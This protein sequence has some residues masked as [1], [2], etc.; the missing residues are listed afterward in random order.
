MTDPTVTIQLLTSADT[1]IL[2]NVAEDVFDNAVNADWAAEFLSDLRHHIF[3]AID[4][5]EVIGMAT[6]VHYLHPDKPPEL[7]VN[8][9]A[10]AAS[11]LKQGVAKRLMTALLDH[12]RVLGCVMAWVGTAVDNLAAQHLYTSVGGHPDPETFI[13]FEFDLKQDKP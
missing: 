6:G 3:V 11:H 8:E 5:G 7:F 2:E 13:M 1:S 9:V 10:V 4:R 12:G